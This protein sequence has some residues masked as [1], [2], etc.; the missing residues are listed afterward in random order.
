MKK[1]ISIVM[2]FVTAIAIAVEF[3]QVV[4]QREAIKN[5]QHLFYQ[6]RWGTVAFLGGSIT[7]MNGY[8]PLVME[9]LK[10][11]FPNAN[12]KCINAGI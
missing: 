10:K 4:I 3:P 12:L 6:N 11:R 5:S 2:A 8:R 1:M 7:E 9:V